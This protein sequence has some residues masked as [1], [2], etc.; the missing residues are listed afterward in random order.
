MG[1]GENSSGPVSRI[2][3]SDLEAILGSTV[4]VVFSFVGNR[5]G[6]VDAE[7][8]SGRRPGSRVENSDLKAIHDHKGTGCTA[9]DWGCG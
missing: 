2:E 4:A 5:R 7:D 8:S 1:D 3:N 6:M 9:F